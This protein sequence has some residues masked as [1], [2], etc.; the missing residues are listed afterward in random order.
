MATLSFPDAS[1]AFIIT[2]QTS[3]NGTD[4]TPFPDMPCDTLDVA[5][6]TG[7]DI[8][9]RRRPGTG[10]GFPI[11]ASGGRAI[12]GINNASQIEVRRL[13]TGTTRVTV[14]AEALRA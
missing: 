6:L 12:V 8:E 3:V 2:V 11:P 13:D 7:A 9:Y 4:W 5:N 14:I 1:A 10:V